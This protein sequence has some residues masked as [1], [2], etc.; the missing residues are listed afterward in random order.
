MAMQY[1]FLPHTAD[2]KFQAY[3]ESIEECFINSSYALKSIFIEGPVKP[4]IKEEIDVFGKD[5]ESLLYNFLEE[6]LG[7]MDVDNFLLSKVLNLTIKKGSEGYELH[8][9]VI[10][11]NIKNYQIQGSVKA[12]TYNEM[13]VKQEGN[14]YLSQVVVDV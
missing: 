5:L 7:I 12:I 3:G 14:G 9:E 6:F 13:F 8:S 4:I 1:K 11:D 2:L 10:G